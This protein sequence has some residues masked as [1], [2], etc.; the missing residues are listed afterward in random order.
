MWKTMTVAAALSLATPALAA[1]VELTPANDGTSVHII[2]PADGASVTS[3]VTV[4]FGLS[5]MGVAPA[6]I[7]FPGTGHHHL[8]VDNA[9]PPMNEPI[10]AGPKHIHYGLGQTEAAVELEPGEHT[11]Q[12]LL[13]DHRHIPHDPPIMSEVVTITVT[14]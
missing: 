4:V 6:G 9:L 10:P 1:D 5:G 12:L 2:S 8:I 13:G 11:L 14:E 7:Q 3:P